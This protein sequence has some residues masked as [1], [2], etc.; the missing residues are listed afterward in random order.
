[1]LDKH[2]AAGE[3]ESEEEHGNEFQH[4]VILP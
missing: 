4:L 3:D 1:L 2:D